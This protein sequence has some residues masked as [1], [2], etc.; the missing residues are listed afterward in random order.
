MKIEGYALNFK[1]VILDI[2]DIRMPTF[3]DIH[4]LSKEE[5]KIDYPWW[6]QHCHPGNKT[7]SFIDEKGT[8]NI[9]GSPIDI[10]A[11][12][13]IIILSTE[14]YW[15]SGCFHYCKVRDEFCIGEYLFR[16]IE[17]TINSHL[18]AICE[19]GVDF[20]Q[21]SKNNTGVYNFYTSDVGKCFSVWKKNFCFSHGNKYGNNNTISLYAKYITTKREINIETKNIRPL[22]VEDINAFH[23]KITPNRYGFQYYH[24]FWLL[25]RADEF[26]A[27]CSSKSKLETC[28]ISSLLDV[29][30]CITTEDKEF[31]VWSESLFQ[32][33]NYLF[34][35]ISADKLICLNSIGKS[36]YSTG[37]DDD[38]EDPLS[39]YYASELCDKIAVWAIDK[40]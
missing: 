36:C 13:P 19:T 27:H 23:E 16:I 10:K 6:L 38:M 30:P 29:H 24:P 2:E 20:S 28:S 11:I 5:L 31:S 15:Q 9:F 14:G 32:I 37:I 18:V 39:F 1:K 40:F 8:F 35:K 3:N 22:S 25:E 4:N 21:Y 26:S 33:G 7:Q 34:L 12:R 17:Q